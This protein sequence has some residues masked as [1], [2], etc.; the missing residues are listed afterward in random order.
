MAWLVVL[1]LGLIP[2]SVVN[3]RRIHHLEDPCLP[4]PPITPVMP[5]CFLA[6]VKGKVYPLVTEHGNRNLRSKWDIYKSVH[7]DVHGGL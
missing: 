6:F 5:S 2:F 3:L 1:M 7:T 4:L